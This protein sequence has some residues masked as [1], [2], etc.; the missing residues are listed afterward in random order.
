MPARVIDTPEPE[1]D[2]MALSLKAQQNIEAV[3]PP[4]SP[5]HG[6]V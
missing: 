2:S 6:C 4:R 3:R 1:V 5:R